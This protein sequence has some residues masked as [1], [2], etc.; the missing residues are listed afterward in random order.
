MSVRAPCIIVN[1]L[2]RVSHKKV[3]L[4]QGLRRYSYLI[5]MT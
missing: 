1:D 3:N 5:N 2:K 4:F